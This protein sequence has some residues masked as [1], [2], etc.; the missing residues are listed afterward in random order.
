[1]SKESFSFEIGGFK[2]LAV[3][4]GTFT[5]APPTFPPPATLLF[6]NAPKALLEQVLLNTTFNCNSG[7]R[8]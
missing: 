5:Y 3:S 1:M 6:T 2:C 4:D 8:G 7:G